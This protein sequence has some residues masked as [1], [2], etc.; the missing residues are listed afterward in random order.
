MALF[1]LKKANPYDGEYDS[2]LK[3]LD[4][5]VSLIL[6]NPDQPRRSFDD[7]SISELAASIKQVGLIQPLIVRRVGDHFE[8]IAGERRLRAVKLLELP[9][10]KCIVSA[11][12]DEEDSALMAIVEN[13]QRE[14]L[15]FFEEAE[16]Y[17]SLLEKLRLTQEELAI[18]VGKSQSFIANKLRI[19]RLSAEI[20]KRVVEAGLSERHTRAL[21]RLPSDAEREEA[22]SKIV[23]RSL[24]VKDTERLVD[25]MLETASVPSE[26]KR[27]PRMIRIFR[28]YKLFVNTVNSACD[29]L[30][31]SGLNVQVEQTD[32]DNGVDIIIRVT[33]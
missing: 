5:P 19:L 15:H 32:R 20:R 23:S 13:L 22:I 28:D 27:R 7:A 2:P 26:V 21:L 24:S 17:A 6:P 9:T 12:Y 31:E 16:C 14:D 30:R 18:R 29:Q 4:I 33:Q 10:V 11:S 1:G 3:L 8:L 25:S